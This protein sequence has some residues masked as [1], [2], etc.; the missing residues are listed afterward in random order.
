M[1]LTDK[2]QRGSVSVGGC[3]DAWPY[4]GIELMTHTVFR[5]LCIFDSY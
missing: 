2:L 5:F 1:H 3:V 4:S